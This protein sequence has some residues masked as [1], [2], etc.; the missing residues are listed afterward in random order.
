[1]EV[2]VFGIVAVPTESVQHFVLDILIEQQRHRHFN[3]RGQSC[4]ARMTRNRTQPKFEST[5]GAPRRRE[6]TEPLLAFH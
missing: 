4:P 2:D 3:L 1:M 5:N 6:L